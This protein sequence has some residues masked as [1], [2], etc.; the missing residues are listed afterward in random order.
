MYFA[1]KIGLEKVEQAE[2]PLTKRIKFRQTAGGVNAT[3]PGQMKQKRHGCWIMASDPDNSCSAETPGEGGE[4]T[5]QIS[6]ISFFEFKTI[7]GNGSPGVNDGRG[8]YMFQK[9]HHGC[10]ATGDVEGVAAGEWLAI[11]EGE[12]VAAG[13]GT[14]DGGKTV[15]GTCSHTERSRVSAP[16]PWDS[17][18][19][20]EMY[21]IVF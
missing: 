17:T 2:E 4:I 15:E 14:G 19:N 12:G 1:S 7:F 16:T 11:G 8:S 9:R 18:L 6:G 3:G 5:G 10:M 13:D 21:F 20:S